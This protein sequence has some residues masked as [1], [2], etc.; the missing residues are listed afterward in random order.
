MLFNIWVTRNCNFRCKYCYVPEYDTNLKKDKADDILK[1]IINQMKYHENKQ[2]EIILN[3]HG[4]E[5]LLNKEAIV[6]FVKNIDDVFQGREISY[7][8]T[9]NASLLDEKFSFFLANKFKYNLS[10]SIDGKSYTH[11]KYRRY[12]NGGSTYFDVIEKAVFL[13]KL[14]PEL[15]IRLTYDSGTIQNLFENIEHLVDMGFKN[16]VAAPNL[17]DKNW[18]EEHVHLF[19]KELEKIFLNYANQKS[20]S[21]NFIEDKLCKKRE[22]CNGGTTSLN[23]DINGNLY[24]CTWSVGYT[25]FVI[26]DVVNGINKKK[27][28]NILNNSNAKHPTCKSCEL[29]SCCVGVRCFIINKV[30]TGCYTTP[31]IWRCMHNNVLF[32]Q[33]KIHTKEEGG[34]FEV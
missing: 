12:S 29:S 34:Y 23:I 10:V 28:S 21:I 33:Q 6:F 24:P 11:D 26:G 13:K 19:E 17:S 18:S 5:P 4:G 31:P 1:F 3:F 8:I 14:Y 32:L 25:E 20:V 7:G 22:K 16:I 15:R 9:T 30:I 2:E 27:L